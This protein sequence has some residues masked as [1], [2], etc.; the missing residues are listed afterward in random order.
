MAQLARLGRRLAYGAAAFFT[1]D[2]ITG[3]AAFSVISLGSLWV[4]CIGFLR[5]SA[6]YEARGVEVAAGY[7]IFLAWIG[8]FVA[9]PLIAE[10]ILLALRAFKIPRAVYRGSLRPTSTASLHRHPPA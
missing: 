4:F 10:V 7:Q 9:I 5:I 2:L 8:V 3:L 1:A 6:E